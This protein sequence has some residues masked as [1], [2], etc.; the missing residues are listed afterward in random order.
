LNYQDFETAW[1]LGIVITSLFVVLLVG[2]W[3]VLRRLRV[4]W[5]AGDHLAA[6][7]AGSVTVLSLVFVLGMLIALVVVPIGQGGA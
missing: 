5:R 7:A 6:T 2:A 3:L 4:L 1:F